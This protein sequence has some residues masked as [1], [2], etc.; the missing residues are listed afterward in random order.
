LI[1]NRG[2]REEGRGKSGRRSSALFRRASRLGVVALLATSLGGCTDWAGYDIDMLW[3]YIPFLS[4]M[5]TSV[6]YDA[7]ELPRLPAPG[8]VPVASPMGEVLPAFTQ[9]E[10]DAVAPTLVNPLSATPEVMARGEMMYLRHCSACHGVE[11]AGDG[12]VV[13]PG[14]FPFATAVRDPATAARSDGY[15]YAVVRAGRG[16]MP[17]YG[18]RMGHLD[19]W[20]VVLYMR[21]LQ[22]MGAAGPI[23]PAP[24]TPE[25]EALADT[26]PGAQ[27]R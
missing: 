25:A 9:T 3:G 11:G 27:V 5:R 15:L 24:L 13:G 18:E 12:T 8:S 17:A 10:L 16:L 21:Q 23:G 22:G 20:A 26:I 4:T 6:A 14:R 2:K 1:R 19:R 7:Y